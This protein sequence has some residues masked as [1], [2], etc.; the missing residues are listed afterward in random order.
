[1]GC[2]VVEVL[3]V[4]EIGDCTAAFRAGQALALATGGKINHL[5]FDL[6]GQLAQVLRGCGWA[7]SPLKRGTANI[8][9]NNEVHKLSSRG[10]RFR[11]QLA[12]GLLV[13]V[14]VGLHAVQLYG[15]LMAEARGIGR[16][17]D[18]LG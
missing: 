2:R 8:N 16:D 14:D 7:G 13:G 5:A 10:N 6:V 15:Q 11:H 9:V 18:L 17:L 1:M 3:Q 4:R 12:Q